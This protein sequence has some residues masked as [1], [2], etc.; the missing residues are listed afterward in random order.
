VIGLDQE[1]YRLLNDL[2]EPILYPRQAFR[3]VDQTVPNNWVWD[4][5][6]EDEYY[7]GPKELERPGF[8]EDYFDG[9]QEAVKQFDEFVRRSGITAS[10]QT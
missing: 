10:G 9:N 8:Y 6:S 7:A 2:G 4:R 3:V 1:S 5:Y